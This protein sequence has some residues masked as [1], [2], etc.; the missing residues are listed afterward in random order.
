MR[1]LTTELKVGLLILSGLG[2][3]VYSS[4]VVTGWR[5]GLADTYRLSIHF[6]NAS[7][8]LPG[9]PVQVAGVK[10]GQVD[11]I[12]LEEGQA[13]VKASIFKRYP[14]YADATATIKS[15][16]I[17][18]DKYIEVRQGSPGQAALQDG[19][20]IVLVLPGSDLDSLVENLSNILNDI[21][22]VTTALRETLGSDAGRQRL[23]NILDRIA[24]A[25]ADI[26]RI[27]DATNKQIDTILN[28]LTGFATNLDTMVAENRSGLKQTI[29]NFAQFSEDLRQLVGRNREALDQIIANLNTFADALGKDTPQITGDLRDILANN[30]ESLN[31]A[32]T[33][34]DSSF[35]K[36]DQTMTNIQSISDKLDKGEGTLG[37]LINDEQTVDELNSALTGINKFLTDADRIKL[38]IG[39]RVEYLTDQGDYKS[40]V[41]V[42]LQPLK[43]RYYLIQLVDNPRG[44]VTQRTIAQTVGN[45]TTTTEETVTEDKFQLSLIIAQRYYDTVI[46]GGLM[47]NTFGL[48]VEQ[49]FGKEDDYRIGLDVWDFGNDLGPHVKLTG[50]WRF[51]SNAFLVVGGD[52]LASDNTQLRDAFF[53]IG[54]HFNEDS[55]KPLFSSLPVGTLTGN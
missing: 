32:I 21:R 39:G 53:G 22:S 30:K 19:D 45:T 41:D 5:P 47:E 14:V 51:F 42:R 28:G 17:L 13:V 50:Y 20:T 26:S 38:D 18:G 11:E 9:S 3:I 27:T 6:N 43:D 46:K 2:I 29:D 31:K 37:K 4:V 49:Y 10:I 16:G 52:D 55:L 48:G 8:L 12:A 24:K 54:L 35:S 1:N 44:K 25:T 34:I 23:D 15:L 7:G 33:S 40:Y 36:L